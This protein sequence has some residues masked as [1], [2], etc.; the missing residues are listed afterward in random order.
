MEQYYS[1]LVGCRLFRLGRREELEEDEFEVE[2][3]NEVEGEEEEA[4]KDEEE[5]DSGVPIIVSL[6]NLSLHCRLEE[7]SGLWFLR[8]ATC[9]GG[10]AH[11]ILLAPSCM[12]GCE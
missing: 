6:W 3:V 2:E 1:I 11:I 4:D 9:R 10:M 7:E 8:F 5:A 12:L